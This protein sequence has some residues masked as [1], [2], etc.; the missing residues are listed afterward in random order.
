MKSIKFIFV[1]LLFFSSS[2][3]AQINGTYD[4]LSKKEKIWIVAHRALTGENIY[5]E[6]SLA[7]IESCIRN[8]IDVVEIDVRETKDG[9]LIVIHDKTV[10]RTTTGKGNVKDYTLEEIKRLRLVHDG[11]VS[12][13]QVPTLEEVLQMVKNKIMVDLDIKLDTITSY[14]KVADLISKHQ[15]EDQMIVFLYDKEEIEAAHRMFKKVNIMPRARSLVDVESIRE[16]YPFISIIHIDEK[17]YDNDMMKRLVTGGIRIWMNS[18]GEY[19]KEVLAG[20]N[21]FDNFFS[22]YPNVNVVQTDC[23]IQL[24]KYL[25]K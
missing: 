4:I 3:S 13:Q 2:C 12:N 24:L 25:K 23:A 10:D 1:L 6:N 11:V 21:G 8:K 20:K 22:K 18:L 19:D 5:P 14:Q 9:K 7:T 17:S 16:K 15:I